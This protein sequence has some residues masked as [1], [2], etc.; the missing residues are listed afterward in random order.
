MAREAPPD[1]EER[2]V[3]EDAGEQRALPA[4]LRGD[5]GKAEPG[6]RAVR[7]Q[8]EPEK[9]EMDAFQGGA[10]RLRAGESGTML[11]RSD[12][13]EAAALPRRASDNAP[14]ERAP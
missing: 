8:R 1:P 14:Q 4:G 2:G 6:L 11:S 5:A 9:D 10:V 12:Y 7:D 3:Q 13:N